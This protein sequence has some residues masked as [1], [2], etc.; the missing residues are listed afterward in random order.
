L[1]P[2][3]TEI[4]LDGSTCPAFT[5]E[6]HTVALYRSDEAVVASEA[7][8]G[9]PERN[10]LTTDVVVDAEASAPGASRTLNLPGAYEVRLFCNIGPD[11][12]GPGTGRDTPRSAA[13]DIETFTLTPTFPDVGVQHPFLADVEWVHAR[14]VA[15]GYSDGTFR[16]T[17][18]VSRQAMVAFLY[19]LEHVSGSEPTCTSAPFSDVPIGDPF[20]GEIEWLSQSGIVDGFSDGTFRP[21]APVSRQA[22]AAFLYRMAREPNGPTPTCSNAPFTDVTVTHPFCAQIR[23]LATAGIA[24]GYA[25]GSFQPA[26]PV[27][28]Q[29]MA[30]FLHRS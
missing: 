25:D 18:A 22:M 1:G 12:G 20:C 29:A 9:G 7:G 28:R 3:G 5:H 13:D 19:R 14:G 26:S 11:W 2:I 4:G 6:D 27:S 30:A 23:W 16:P 21:T 8:I 10:L 24:D 17:T 15:D